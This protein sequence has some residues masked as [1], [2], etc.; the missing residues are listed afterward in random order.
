MRVIAKGI[1]VMFAMIGVVA[2]IQQVR[3][4]SASPL[5][6]AKVTHIGIMVNDIEKTSKMFEEVFGATVPKAFEFGP[7]PLPPGV[8]DAASSKVKFATFKIGDIM[9]EMIEP[10]AGPG[11]HRDHI[12][13]FG[14]GLQ[15][16]AFSVPDAKGAID[17]LVARGGSLTMSGY[18][19]MKDLLGFTAEIAGPPQARPGQ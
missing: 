17:A 2:S 4:Q 14:Q 1:V 12:D 18:V 6:E 11:P 8:A 13:K 19:D 16:I 9:F 7:L 15:H 3:G 5:S 10:V